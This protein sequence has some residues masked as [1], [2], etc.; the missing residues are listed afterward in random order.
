M[1]SKSYL[2]IEGMGRPLGPPPKVPLAQAAMGISGQVSLGQQ[3]LGVAA[4]LRLARGGSTCYA[5][6]CGLAWAGQLQLG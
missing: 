5:C 6:S 1:N 2:F 4:C 3:S